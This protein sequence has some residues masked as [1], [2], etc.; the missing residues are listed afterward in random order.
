MNRSLSK[1]NFKFSLK[2]LKEYEKLHDLYDAEEKAQVP[3]LAKY[4][5]DTA[6]EI[7]NHTQCEKPF[8]I[9]LM[10]MTV[11]ERSQKHLCQFAVI[12]NTNHDGS[13]I[14][15][16]LVWFC[17]KSKKIFRLETQLCDLSP[18]KHWGEKTPPSTGIMTLEHKE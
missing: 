16:S 3:F 2:Q 14:Q 10:V 4:A 1:K 7:F 12:K 8:Y 9:L 17:D 13:K 11:H 18:H 5:W 6:K 15:N